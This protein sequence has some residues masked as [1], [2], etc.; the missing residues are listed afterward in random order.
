MTYMQMIELVLRSKD[1]TDDDKLKFIA[2][3]IN[4]EKVKSYNEGFKNGCQRGRETAKHYI[5]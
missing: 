1:I 5:F 4:E 2:S 3:I